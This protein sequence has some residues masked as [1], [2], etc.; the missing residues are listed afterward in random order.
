MGEA[1]LYKAGD[2][3]ATVTRAV[4]AAPLRHPGLETLLLPARRWGRPRAGGGWAGGGR[5]GAL[6]HGTALGSQ[7]KRHGPLP[8]APSESGTGA[9]RIPRAGAIGEIQPMAFPTLWDH[10]N[11]PPRRH[12]GPGWVPAEAARGI[13]FAAMVFARRGWEAAKP[14]GA[15]SRQPSASPSSTFFGQ[16][17]PNFPKFMVS[18]CKGHSQVPQKQEVERGRVPTGWCHRALPS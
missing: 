3:G 8:R 7:G 18:E 14:L 9:E 11:S 10:P 12:G 4:P 2:V 13:F 17:Q 5:R 1:G 6:G 16:I 15:G